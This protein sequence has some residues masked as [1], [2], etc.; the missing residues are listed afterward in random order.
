MKTVNDIERERQGTVWGALCLFMMMLFGAIFFGSL[1]LYIWALEHT[2][3][4][5][6]YLHYPLVAMLIFGC[7]FPGLVTWRKLRKRSRYAALYGLMI[8]AAVIIAV[9]IYLGVPFASTP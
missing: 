9:P 7:I 4:S 5:I 2:K 1:S 8:A 6:V 3:D